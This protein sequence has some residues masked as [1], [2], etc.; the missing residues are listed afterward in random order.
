MDYI[1]VAKCEA[2]SDKAKTTQRFT[3]A[4]LKQ[5]ALSDYIMT[6]EEHRPADLRSENVLT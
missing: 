5:R 1:L 6:Y 4:A 2:F 3:E